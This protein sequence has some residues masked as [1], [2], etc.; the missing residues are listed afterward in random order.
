MELVDS[1]PKY[2]LYQSAASMSLKL[3][4][5]KVKCKTYKLE[6]QLVTITPLLS[7]HKTQ[8]VSRNAPICISIN[9]YLRFT[10][11]RALVREV[12]DMIACTSCSEV[13]L[14]LLNVSTRILTNL[15]ACLVIT[16]PNTAIQCL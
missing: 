1:M 13:T 11:S 3:I 9:I 12:A 8:T 7:S 5:C 14:L 6:S 15:L 10:L 4:K 2:D 16:I